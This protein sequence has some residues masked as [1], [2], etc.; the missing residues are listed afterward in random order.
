MPLALILLVVWILLLLRFPRVMLPASFGVLGVA[1][2]IGGAVAVKQWL[3]ARQ[4]ARIDIRIQY[5]PQ[6]CEFG[7]PLQVSITNNSDL[8][9]RRISWQMLARQP[10]YSSNLLD[11]GSRDAS[12]ETDTALAPGAHWQQC[13]AVPRLRSGYRAEQLEYQAQHLRADLQR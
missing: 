9:A 6:E 8:T 4:L 2:L 7:K 3:D 12:W 10:G 5:L 11:V 13:L 1:L